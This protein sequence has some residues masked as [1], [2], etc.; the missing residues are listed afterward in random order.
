MLDMARLQTT[1]PLCVKVNLNQANHSQM[2]V[3]LIYDANTSEKEK[4]VW[5][6]LC[7]PNI[8]VMEAYE[9]IYVQ[10]KKE[11]QSLWPS[12]CS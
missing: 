1:L 6:K 5:L 11:E 10:I 3:Q 9:Y 2:H 12:N 4:M 7:K 8:I